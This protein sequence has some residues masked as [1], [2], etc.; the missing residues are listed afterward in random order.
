MSETCTTEL[1][2][3]AGGGQEWQNGSSIKWNVLLLIP[4]TQ[5]IQASTTYHSKNDWLL[6]LQNEFMLPVA[7]IVEEKAGTDV[8]ERMIWWFD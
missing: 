6:K 8:P 2:T 3:A 7:L 1:E 5:E 4:V